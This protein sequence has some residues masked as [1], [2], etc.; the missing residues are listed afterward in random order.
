MSERGGEMTIAKRDIVEML[1]AR[2]DHQRAIEADEQLPTLVHVE[3]HGR[4]L[5]DLGLDPALL[6]RDL[7]RAPRRTLAGRP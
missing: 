5:R 6:M 2:S 1:L 3:L 7:A 4:L